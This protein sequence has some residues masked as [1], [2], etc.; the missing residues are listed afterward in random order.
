MIIST[1]GRYALRIMLD[2]ARSAEDKFISL[3]DIC[4]REKVSLKYI[5]S[6]MPELY[7]AGLIE[8]RRGKT[9]GYRLAK[10]AGECSVFEIVSS[11]ETDISPVA[12]V[13]E[14]A[15]GCE[16]AA[17]CLTLPMWLKLGGIIEDYLKGITLK[18]LLDRKV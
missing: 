4:E 15:G 6:I 1:K 5:E 12:C 10:E 14:G 8:S 3:K 16:R 17:E 9:G 11:V 18:D 7:K 13:A 2:L